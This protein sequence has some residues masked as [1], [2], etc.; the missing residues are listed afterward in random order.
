M[1]QLENLGWG[2]FF[3]QQLNSAE[4]EDLLPARIAE[5]LKGTYRIYAECGPMLATTCGRLAHVVVT[6]DDLPAVG[7]WVLARPLL[8]EERAVIHRVLERRTKLSR[9]M[10]GERTTEQIL[11]A[12]V[13]TVFLVAS[14][15]QEFNPRRIERY[16]TVIWESGARPVVV[17]NKAD[18]CDRP[19]AVLAEVE[20]VAPGVPAHLTSAVGGDG[21]AALRRHLQQGETAVFVGSSGVGK[22]SLI[23]CLLGQPS[24]IV[25]QIRHADGRGRHTTT[26]RQLLIAPTG[27]IIIDTPGLRELQLWDAEAGLARAF[28]DISSLA[29]SCAFSDCKHSTEPACAVLQALEEGTLDKARISNYRKLEKEQAHIERKQNKSL[30]IAEKKRWKRIH[31]DN[32]QRMRLRGR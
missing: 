14:L 18:L 9:K 11:A 22:S 31:M 16:L 10:A 4:A 15:N 32:R 3:Q 28:A 21:L 25:Q 20:S 7:D 23:N 26:S 1:L 24:Q 27:G 29:S 30:E 6:R 5:E 19:D 2:P 13:D 17:L 12:N 8:A